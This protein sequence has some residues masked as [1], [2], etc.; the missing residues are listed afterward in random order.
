MMRVKH[1]I[2][3]FLIS[4]MV[5]AFSADNENR[6]TVEYQGDLYATTFDVPAKFVGKYSGDKTGYLT[7]NADG[8][9][10]YQYDVFG[11]APPSCV[12]QAI[13][14]EWGFIL[15][16]EGNI[17]KNKRQYGYSYPML[18]KSKG[19]TWFQGC[20][21]EVMMDYILEKE[22]GLHVSSSDD[23]FKAKP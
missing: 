16:K 20:R 7:L 17:V 8:T 1:I 6:R 5:S 14:M 22:D 4:L 9:G 23:W 19:T 11:Y 10:M 21:N 2:T 13:K 18:L 15:D 3:F 12:R